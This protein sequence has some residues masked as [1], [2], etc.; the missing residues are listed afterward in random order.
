MARNAQ[1]NNIDHA[2]IRVINGY[3]EALGD[4][5]MACPVF[6]YEFRNL[7]PH[8][9]IVFAKDSATGGFRPLALFGLEDGENLFLRGENRWDADYIPLAMRMRPFLIGFSGDS[10]G[11][12]QMEVHIDLDHPK[13][14]RSAGEPLFLEH[15]GHAPYLQQ[16]SKLLGEVHDAEQTVAAFSAILDELGLL[17]PFTLDITLDD[18]SRGRLAGYYIIAEEAL[19]ALDAGALWRLQSAGVLQPIY[20]AVAALAQFRALIDRRNKRLARS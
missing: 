14:S 10:L 17:D 20:M 19:Y 4:A 11:G 5:V 3:G 12:R 13:V 2:E 9:P 7:Q 18:G 16:V 15:G 6:P 1:L 8:Y